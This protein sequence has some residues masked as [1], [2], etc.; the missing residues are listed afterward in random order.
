VTDVT[1]LTAASTGVGLGCGPGPEP[2][3]GPGDDETGAAGGCGDPDVGVIGR[4]AVA[5]GEIVLPLEP[6]PVRRADSGGD[7]R[8]G[9]APRPAGH[10]VRHRDNG[11]RATAAARSGAGRGARQ[12]DRAR[13][14]S[15]RPGEDLA[16]HT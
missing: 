15:R 10:E 16:E 13:A 9:P 5:P 7:T 3:D 1:I 4:V 12:S 8:S 11:Q 2:E 14:R 6:T